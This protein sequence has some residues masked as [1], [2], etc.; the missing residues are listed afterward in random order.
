MRKIIFLRRAFWS[1]LAVLFVTGCQPQK[2]PDGLVLPPTHLKT[3]QTSWAVIDFPL[4]N[5]RKEPHRTSDQ[6]T[7]LRVGT[8]V[9][10]LSSTADFDEIDEKKDR[11]YQ[12]Q[13]LGMR[14]WV[15]GAY[16]K[17]YD[18]LDKARDS[19]RALLK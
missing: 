4:L 6:V 2:I 3:L 17:I 8:I 1:F 10:I 14:G 7:M 19:A 13:H 9:E 5:I 18:T 12:I 11:W 16:V 15:F